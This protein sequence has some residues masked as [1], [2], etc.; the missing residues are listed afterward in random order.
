MGFQTAKDHPSGVSPKPG[1]LGPD[2][3]DSSLSFDDNCCY[4]IL[5]FRSIHKFFQGVKNR[6]DDRAVAISKAEDMPCPD[7]SPTATPMFG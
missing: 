6:N 7:T 3:R 4:V 5:Y 2:G 1:P